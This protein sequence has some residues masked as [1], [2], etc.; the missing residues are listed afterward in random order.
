MILH[1]PH[2]R[3]IIPEIVAND[4][5][6]TSSRLQQEL[7]LMTDHYCDDL[8]QL[9]GAYQVVFPWS[10]LFC[11]V[12]RFEADADEPMAAFGQGMYYTKTFSGDPLRIETHHA[13]QEAIR[14]FRKHHQVLTEAVD[15]ELSSRNISLIV[16]CHSYSKNIVRK[17]FDRVPLPDVC[18]GSDEFH[19]P[20]GFANDLSCY[21]QKLGY[22]SSI[23]YPFSGS[24]VPMKYYRKN[25]R[26]ISIMIEINRS[27]YLDG[28][29]DA[30]S[31]HYTEIKQ[32]CASL[33]FYIKEQIG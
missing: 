13:K 32:L 30:K 16:D 8:F 11:D 3:T 14:I 23:N 24:I 2:S 1:I 31:T 9:P 12:E 5:L 29:S 21:A 33:L 19:T 17:N 10:R 26:V 4:L 18:I 20:T 7:V 15:G 27:L 22:S 6:I 28:D 25:K